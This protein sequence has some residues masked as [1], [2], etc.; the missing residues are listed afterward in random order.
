MNYP[1]TSSLQEPQR[2][3]YIQGERRK[4][5]EG[6]LLLVELLCLIG[7][8]VDEDSHESDRDLYCGKYI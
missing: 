3:I 2:Y 7:F 6:S 5:R 8:D 1:F 4:K